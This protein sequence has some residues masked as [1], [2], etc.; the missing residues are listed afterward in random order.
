MTLADLP[1]AWLA[2]GVVALAAVGVLIALY[3][4]AVRYRWVRPDTRWVP[5]FC[6]MD[7]DTCARVVDSDH[8]HLFG[9]PNA[10]F[11]LAWY[12]VAGGAGVAGLTTGAVPLCPTLVAVAGLTVAV[13][14]YLAWA[15]LFDLRTHCNLCYTSHVLNGALLVLFVAACV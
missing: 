10:L 14:V 12:L 15:L 5:S 8:G 6:R 4:T 2:G 13:S 3:F 1:L 7:E 11:G 9:L